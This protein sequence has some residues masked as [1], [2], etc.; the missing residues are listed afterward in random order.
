MTFPFAS[1]G[2]ARGNDPAGTDARCIDHN[3]QP[4]ADPTVEAVAYVAVLPRPSIS[5]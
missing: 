4:A 5:T 3:E 1:I 2:L